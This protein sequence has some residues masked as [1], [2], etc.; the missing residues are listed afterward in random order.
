MDRESFEWQPMRGKRSR[1]T[2]CRITPLLLFIIIGQLLLEPVSP[3]RKPESAGARS[4][5]AR[6][7][8]FEVLENP[9][10]LATST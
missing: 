9:L 5:D 7:E 3:L 1:R 10:R 2:L 6:T 8:R 4:S